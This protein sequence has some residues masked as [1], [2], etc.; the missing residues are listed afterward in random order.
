M[1]TRIG[2]IAASL[3]TGVLMAGN[4][5]LAAGYALREQ[6]AVGQGAA[7]AGSAARGDDPSM[8]FFN[9]AAM[10]WLPG[11][12]A[13]T[14][15]S[16]IWPEAAAQSGSA[17]RNALLGGSAITGSLGGDAALDAVIPALYGTAAVGERWRL[18]LGV[19][20]PW[21][22][23]TK[24]PAD[25]IGRYHALTSSLRTINI[26]PAVS[27]RPQPNLAFGAALQ[28]QYADA[29]LSNAVDFGAVGAVSGLGRFGLLPGTRDG[30][31]T[32]SGD[33]TALGWQIGA[34]WEPLAG[35]RLGLAFRSA[36]FHELRGEASFQ[37]VP[38]PLNASAQFANTGGRA[39]LTTPEV[40]SLGVTQRLNE[41]WTLLAEADW[42]NWSRF[43]ELVVHFDSGRPPSVT[44][45][46][47][48]D[49]WFLSL[50]TE[51]RATEGLT[52]RAGFA[53]DRTPVPTE[54]RT[55][56]IPDS[57]RYW[58]SIGASYQVT[59]NATLSAA[60]T[61]VFADDAGVALRDRG[62]GTSD[63]LRGDLNMAYQ[64]SVDILA[65]QARFAF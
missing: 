32:T 41:R 56:R 37:G 20:M 27:W 45:E 31:A 61:H 59:N 4:G 17:S 34:Q 38:A 50:G 46:R 7:F 49:S 44:E 25:F 28:I 22:L 14:V 63:F 47:W 62:P 60:Y 12:Q 26:A 52:L 11:M 16:A 5:A 21:G 18:G 3:A 19:T 54:T 36:I 29:R 10:A 65:V 33:D 48:R 51:Y 43:R 15:A 55:P 2:L 57:D 6:S 13:A 24:Y 1:K 40:L 39:K 58:L 64:A 23:V 53:Y 30:R 42:T 8:I 35:T 9:P